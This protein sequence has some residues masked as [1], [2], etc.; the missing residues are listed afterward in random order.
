MK[1]YFTNN[2]LYDADN[3]N[4]IFGEYNRFVGNCGS[5]DCSDM[6]VFKGNRLIK[7]NTLPLTIGTGNG[8]MF[9]FSGNYFADSLNDKMGLAPAAANVDVRTGSTVH[10]AATVE[11]YTRRRMDYTYLNWDLTLRSDSTAA[12]DV[13]INFTSG[14]Y[15]TGTVA[16]ENILGINTTGKVFRDQ[17]VP[18]DCAVYAMPFTTS[19]HAIVNVYNNAAC[20]EEYLVDELNL[21]SARNVFYVKATSIDGSKSEI[22]AIVI[23][24]QLNSECKVLA[25][26]DFLVDQTAKTITGHVNGRYVFLPSNITV[27]NGATVE[28]YEE[29]QWQLSTSDFFRLSASN[30]TVVK[31]VKVTSEDQSQ[32]AFYK[33][34]LNYAANESN[35]AV[36][37]VSAV[38]GMIR[39][40]T[41]FKMSISPAASTFSFKPIA[42][43]GSDVK[44]YN[45]TELITPDENGVY[46][47]KNGGNYNQTLRLTATKGSVSMNYLLDIVKV[48]SGECELI[49]IDQAVKTD[50]GFA[51]NFYLAEAVEVDATV[52]AGATYQVYADYTCTTAYAN[53]VVTLTDASKSIAYIKVTA[54]NGRASKVYKVTLLAQPANRNA[55]PVVTGTIGNAV[56]TAY[57]TGEKEF[58]LYLPAGATSVTL[59]AKYD[60]KDA[61]AQ[62]SLYVDPSHAIALDAALTLNTKVTKAYLTNR[63]GTYTLTRTIA[64]SSEG[65]K[66]VAV[67]ALIGTGEWT[68]NII[69]DRNVVTYSDAPYIA[70]WVQ[71]YVE[72]LNNGRYRIF[73]GDDYGRFNCDNNITRNEITAVAT[74]VMGLDVSKYSSVELKF[75]DTVADW[76]Q[77]YLKAAVATSLINGD[78]DGY[79]GKVYFRGD[80]NATRE[81]VIKILVAIMMNQ[82]GIDAAAAYYT[83]NK[84]E[85]D[86]YY[87]VYNFADEKEISEWAV[88]YIH[89]AVAKYNL[90]NGSLIDGKYYLKPQQN[91]TRAEVAKIAACMMGY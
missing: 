18:A 79:T 9:D 15:G 27:S 62:T 1:F 39:T 36:A 14:M 48:A 57:L 85:L 30:P 52:S 58:T 50:A 28:L 51:L 61:S 44:V 6:I 68:I 24:R 71:P 40:E 59:S 89:L 10:D 33:L 74:R 38:D 19:E 4:V 22:A 37:G 45:G 43:M 75:D 60:L 63:A 83:A 65:A 34:V 32:N 54:E 31:Y 88:P 12:N 41:G 35:V 29:N 67:S 78:L 56:Y 47:V 13:A 23:D 73:E 81:Q 69:S 46:T 17:N 70:D 26:G 53:N 72:Y 77:P 87:N 8:T 11:T 55:T 3:E 42:Y 21:T 91:I 5:E 90:V 49:S 20:T 25:F 84:N 66:E 86:Q 2:I 16:T 82:D 80:D 7:W 76:I 64:A